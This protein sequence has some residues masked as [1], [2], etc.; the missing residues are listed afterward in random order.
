MLVALCLG[1]VWA[2]KQT[3]THP[4]ISPQC[5]SAE[6]CTTNIAP[7]YTGT[8]TFLP[9]TVA[10]D[11]EVCWYIHDLQGYLPSLRLQLVTHFYTSP[12][13]AQ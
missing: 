8:R 10:T 4:S 12:K 7:R 3:T 13:L 6:L 11:M 9:L 1:E 5:R 2:A